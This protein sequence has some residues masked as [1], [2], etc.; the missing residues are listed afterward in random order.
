MIRIAKSIALICILTILVA[1]FGACGKKIKEYD[2]R[3]VIHDDVYNSSGKLKHE[4]DR[5]PETNEEKT[6]TFA[7]R[8]QKY[9]Y[10]NNCV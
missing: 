2:S 1:L 6:Y 9:D 5:R 4:N 7:G 10:V 3:S 8:A